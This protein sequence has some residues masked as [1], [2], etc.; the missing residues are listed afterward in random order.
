MASSSKNAPPVIPAPDSIKNPTY[1]EGPVSYPPTS[2]AGDLE[3]IV[4]DTKEDTKEFGT[5]LMNFTE[6]GKPHLI[7]LN[8]LLANALRSLQVYEDETH[9]TNLVR[10]AELRDHLDDLTYK[11]SDKLLF[12]FARYG[13]TGIPLRVPLETEGTMSRHYVIR[14]VLDRKENLL[15]IR[16]LETPINGKSV[17]LASLLRE[18]STDESGPLGDSSE[19]KSTET[20]SSYCQYPNYNI[21]IKAAQ[22]GWWG[23]KWHGIK[24]SMSKARLLRTLPWW[25][26]SETI[27]NSGSIG[28]YYPMKIK[29][30]EVRFSVGD[31]RN[32]PL[33]GYNTITDNSSC[34]YLRL[35]Q[36]FQRLAFEAEVPNHHLA[37]ATFALA[38][39]VPIAIIDYLSPRKNNGS[40][41]YSPEK[42]STT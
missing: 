29:S 20:T 22:L 38:I 12:I 9:S 41:P 31:Q 18:K 5:V 32:G 3:H 21:T 7:D 1:Q 4:V 39:S 25:G 42:V 35:R 19:G 27:S 37:Q 33:N 17:S 8:E 13:N 11:V 14:V 23:T 34:T 6:N 16:V 10:S 2:P 30:I 36:F 26:V 15:N 28:S 24:R 40:V